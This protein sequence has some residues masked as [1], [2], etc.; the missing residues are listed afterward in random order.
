ML[1]RGGVGTGEALAPKR[2]NQVFG[3]G[4]LTIHIR[5]LW[6]LPL[7]LHSLLAFLSP[8]ALKLSE[9]SSAARFLMEILDSKPAYV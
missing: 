5:I 9:I 4:A 1:L 6:Y 3:D 2:H 7:P 8:L